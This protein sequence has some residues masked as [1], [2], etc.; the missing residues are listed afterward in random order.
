MSPYLSISLSLYLPNS[1]NLYPNNN[2][3]QILWNLS[4]VLYSKPPVAPPLT[5]GCCPYSGS[6]C[7]LP[8]LPLLLQ[9]AMA[10]A[11]MLGMFPPQGICSYCSF[12]LGSFQIRAGL[13]LSCLAHSHF[14]SLSSLCLPWYPTFLIPLGTAS[15]CKNL[16]LSS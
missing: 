9:T 13:A 4:Q 12:C 6:R 8:S 16:F 11:H 10:S 15:C 2:P 3:P 5:L 14:F 1:H 7:P